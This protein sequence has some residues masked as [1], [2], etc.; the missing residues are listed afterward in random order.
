MV[1]VLL[2]MIVATVILVVPIVITNGDASN[3]SKH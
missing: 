2:A 1:I 3:N